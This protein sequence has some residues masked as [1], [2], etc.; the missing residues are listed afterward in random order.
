MRV[1][2][3]KPRFNYI[4]INGTNIWCIPFISSLLLKKSRVE[5]D[6]KFP[7]TITATYN[8]HVW[9]DRKNYVTYGTNLY[10]QKKFSV[11]VKGA[12]PLL[13][14]NFRLP[15]RCEW[16]LRSFGILRSVEWWYC[17]RF[18]TTGR[19]Q[20]QGSNSPRKT[21]WSL[22]MGRIGCSEASVRNY[23]S[24]LRKIPRQRTSSLFFV[25]LLNL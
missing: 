17:R 25:L 5:T 14:H 10:W 21:A 15:P 9:T 20:L 6:G 23:H 11:A 22:N 4:R 3:L 19:S 8:D 18:G 13:L 2:V 24:T 16:D 7:S 12:T 1:S